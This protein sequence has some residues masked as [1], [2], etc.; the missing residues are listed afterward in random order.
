M[1]IFSEDRIFREGVQ[2]MFGYR[3]ETISMKESKGMVKRKG[4]ERSG[5]T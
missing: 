5:S 1:F 4:E 3:L 2:W